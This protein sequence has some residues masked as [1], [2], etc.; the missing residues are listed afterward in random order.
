[1]PIHVVNSG[2]CLSVIAAR[3]GFADYK[4]IYDH[5]DNAELKKQRPNPNL[6]YPGDEVFIPARGGKTVEIAAGKAYAFT[7]KRAKKALRIVIQKHDGTALGGEAGILSIGG[8]NI[9][10][11]SDGGGKIEQM[12]PIDERQ[13]TLTIAGRVLKLRFGNLN[14][15]GETPDG[16]VTGAKGRLKN[17]GYDVPDSLDSFDDSTHAAI[18]LF[19]HDH[20]LIVTGKLDAATAKQLASTH[21]C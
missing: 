17:L 14:P 6:I 4:T 10:V 9:P 3:Y 12:V 8:K 1:M 13:A 15:I 19:Q 21:G 18:A 2:E 20:K 7:L 5:P 11:T 16:G